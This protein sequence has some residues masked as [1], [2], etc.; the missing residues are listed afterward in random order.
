VLRD[1]G[2]DQRSTRRAVAAALNGYAHLRAQAAAAAP[3]AGPGASAGAGGEAVAGG[4][5][6]VLAAVRGLV[7]PLTARL[8]DIERRLD[9]VA[10]PPAA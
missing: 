10:G 6:A 3:Q 9:A 1:A 5:D 2:A 8:D 7:E 4:Q